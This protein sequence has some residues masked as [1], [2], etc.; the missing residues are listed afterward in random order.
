M[1]L[2]FVEIYS[3]SFSSFSENRGR[4]M[5]CTVL[6]FR[7][8]RHINALRC[9]PLGQLNCESNEE[10]IVT[11]TV[12][13]QK[14]IKPEGNLENVH[15]AKGVKDAPEAEVAGRCSLSVG[16]VYSC[17]FCDSPNWIPPGW[18]LFYC[19]SCG[20]LNWLSGRC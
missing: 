9:W 18:T 11:E 17:W 15:V 3:C 12:T 4:V 2:D 8:S 5:L 13:W 6:P 14:A 1:G 16:E 7:G 10:T 19:W 20:A